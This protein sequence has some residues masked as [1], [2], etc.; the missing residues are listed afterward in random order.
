[1]TLV[2]DFDELP[3]ALAR[4]MEWTNSELDDA[5]QLLSDNMWKLQ[6][7]LDT[8]VRFSLYE[9]VGQGLLELILHSIMNFSLENQNN[10]ILIIVVIDIF[11]SF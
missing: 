2:L 11:Y 7:F 9:V 4:R 6:N 5:L 3:D 1:M 10:D 8:V